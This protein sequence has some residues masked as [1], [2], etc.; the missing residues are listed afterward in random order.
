MGN[1]N[2]FTATQGWIQER[3]YVGTTLDEIK[4]KKMDDDEET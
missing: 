3:V 2:N 4:T 1:M